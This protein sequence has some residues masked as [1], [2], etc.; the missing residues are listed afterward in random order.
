MS[1]AIMPL[2]LLSGATPPARVADRVTG[3]AKFAVMPLSSLGTTQ[4]AAQ[5]LARILV[6]ELAR[7][8]GGRLIPPN[9]LSTKGRAARA[10]IGECEGVVVCLVE[11]VGALGWDAFVVGNV[12][13]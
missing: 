1:A 3:Y 4:A 11:V 7:I 6:S 10:A 13:G 9:E 8:A 2:A 12:A 5:V